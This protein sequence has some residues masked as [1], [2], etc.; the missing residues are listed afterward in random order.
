[1][2][3]ADPYLRRLTS[4]SALLTKTSLALS[5]FVAT[6]F[7][8][9]EKVATAENPYAF[10]NRVSDP[11]V[12]QLRE[13]VS[14]YAQNFVG[15]HYHYAGRSPRTGFDC[16]GFTS[17]ILKEFDLN[18]SCSSATQSKQGE[19]ISLD[20]I[21]PGDLVFFGRGNHIQHVAMVV[22]CAADG[23]VCVHST[24]SRG[25]IVENISKSRYWSSRLLFARDIITGQTKSVAESAE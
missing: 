14:G 21:L 13:W 24:S 5:L 3:I 12:M 1:M 11:K 23:I 2:T 9:P 25:V 10:E 6:S 22:E 17:Y 4:F 18:A 20:E 19:R 8:N 15:I 7:T 16:S